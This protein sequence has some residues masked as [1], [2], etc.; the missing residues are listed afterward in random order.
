MRKRSN[1]AR[2]LAVALCMFFAPVSELA[3]DT[4]PEDIEFGSRLVKKKF[5]ILGVEILEPIAA[6]LES[7]A[8]KKTV[9]QALADAHRVL[10]T[11]DRPDLPVDKA[12]EIQ[13]DHRKK[14]AKYSSLLL[15]L[16]PTARPGSFDELMA[17]RNEAEALARKIP[18]A[19]SAAEKKLLVDQ[20]TQ[21]YQAVIAGFLAL[22]NDAKKKLEAHEDK[23]PVHG[24]RARKRWAQKL[25]T[26]QEP[27]LR[28]G[29]E[30]N[31]SRHLFLNAP[32]GMDDADKT[33]LLKQ[34][35][36]EL[37]SLCSE[38]SE[39]A[40]SIVG[41]LTL[42]RAYT[43]LRK[44]AEAEQSCD[45]ALILIDEYL[46]RMPRGPA[47]RKAEK[48]MGPWRDKLLSAWAYAKGKQGEF[49]SAIRRLK[50]QQGPDVRIRLG[51][52]HLMKAQSLRQ[53]REPDA[54]QRET[55]RGR[56]IL[57]AVLAADE[58]LAPRVNSV[59]RRYGL[60]GDG[61]YNVFIKLR[62]AVGRADAPTIIKLAT[63]L[64][65]YGDAVPADKRDLAIRTLAIAYKKERLYYEAYVVFM[66]MATSGVGDDPEGY[67]TRAVACL[68][69]QYKT[70]Q[71]PADKVLLEAAK[72]ELRE[73][74]GGPGAEYG[75]A[76]EAKANKNYAEAIKLFPKVPP[77]SLYYEPALE[78]L[79]EC[80]ILEAKRLRKSDPARS[81][82]LLAQ[83]KATLLKF[84]DQIKKPSRFPKVIQRRKQLKAAAI[85]R[86]ATVDMWKGK[87]DYRACVRRTEGYIKQFPEA[88]AV[89]PYVRYLRV[90]ALVPLGELD[91][92][93][94]ELGWLRAPP[95]ETTEKQRTAWKKMVAHATD[96]LFRAYVD[97][98]RALRAEAQ[99]LAAEARK[100]PAKAQALLD[101]AAEKENQGNVFAGKALDIITAAI[102]QNPD[103]PY[104]RYWFAI[105]E[106]HR[107]NQPNDERFYLEQFLKRFGDK[108]GLSAKQKQ[109]VDQAWVMLGMAH[110]KVGEFQQ[111]HDV[112]TK[113]LRALKETD[114]QYWSVLMYVGK[115][116]KQL[117][118]GNEKYWDEAMNIFGRLHKRLKE[119]SPDWWDVTVGISE[120]RD[121]QGEYEDTLL[122]VARYVTTTKDLGGPDIRRRYAAVL[123]E[124]YRS[125]KKKEERQQALNLLADVQCAELA[126]LQRDKK[127]TPAKKH[128][129]MLGVIAAF[130]LVEMHY[131][132]RAIRAKFR[133]F[134]EH[135]V[136]NA[137]D[138]KVKKDATELLSELKD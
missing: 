110:Y 1:A 122:A 79:G 10:S 86:L 65:G 134:V 52:L 127:L 46:Q 38:Y 124:A 103:Q 40:Y 77:G 7:D 99:K 67:A 18:A 85:Y 102:A 90:R 133:P 69:N 135:V 3:G 41:S 129:A 83:G 115:S 13:A 75:R 97:T 96:L 125:S 22:T 55:K 76:A 44:F 126:A 56:D 2:V 95:E 50:D 21:K 111:A 49:D 61:W 116:A 81:D 118:S 101:Q 51:E 136:K 93:E 29:V 137:K 48:E 39:W 68:Q 12:K 30:L 91:K 112:L 45:P 130:R 43:D 16:Q 105:Y 37:E 54:A 92:A 64:L 27:Y 123:K 24:E 98:S 9:Y 74:F 14:A 117:S 82:R 138:P 108:R 57:R 100:T 73:K 23:E 109:E 89:H 32:V 128:R 34:I 132:N 62:L 87:E 20:V 53:K 66:H 71:D 88:K 6:R 60:A 121:I 31:R 11:R 26:L 104:D 42:A 106:Y 25:Q 59:L 8:Q 131:G 58:R 114:P 15:R 70:T 84:L 47:R 113:R 33:K 119:F 28:N 5:Y 107:Q 4:L 63:K 120:L 17:R 78:Q 36:D 19:R 80:Y 35:T 94:L 72:K